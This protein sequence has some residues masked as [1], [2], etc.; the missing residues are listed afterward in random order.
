MKC[1][2]RLQSI[3]KVAALENAPKIVKKKTGA[4]GSGK[5]RAKVESLPAQGR[6][7]YYPLFKALTIDAASGIDAWDEISDEKII[8]NWRA[9]TDDA[10]HCAISE[11][12]TDGEEYKLWTVVRSLVSPRIITRAFS[13][14]RLTTHHPRLAMPLPRSGAT[15]S[16]R[17]PVTASRT[18][19][20]YSK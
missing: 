18:S 19:L 3:A 11:D 7:Q 1:L 2:A 4:H 6:A 17:L 13:L 5:T 20:C 8:E 10:P 14:T 15:S 16:G 9:A 12:P